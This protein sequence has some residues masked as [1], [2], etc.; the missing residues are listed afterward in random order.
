MRLEALWF[1]HLFKLH[2]ETSSVA[3]QEV[4]KASGVTR[5]SGLSVTKLTRVE[6]SMV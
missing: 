1:V 6:T 2:P 3:S 5:V 4:A